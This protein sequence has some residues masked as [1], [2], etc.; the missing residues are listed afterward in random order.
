MKKTIRILLICF[1]A[2]L[3]V[4]SLWKLWTIASAYRAGREHYDAL[5]HYITITDHNGEASAP[6]E[7]GTSEE[8]GVAKDSVDLSAWPQVDFVQLS[9]I[10]PDIVGWIYIEG[11]DINYP[12]VQGKDNSYYLNRLF[13]G[14]YNGSGSIFMDYRC[15]S[16]FS[17]RNSVIYGHHM[18]DKSMFG[19]LVNYK[20]QEFYDAHSVALLVTPDAY[21]KLQIFSGYVSNT[22]GDAWELSFSDYEFISWLHDIQSRSCFK[23]DCSPTKTD[24]IVTLSTCTYEFDSAKFVLHGYISEVI[25]NTEADDA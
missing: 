11:T 20:K 13:D 6:F 14:S 25:T 2:S 5:G 3:L 12:I 16:D 19:G 18:G 23:T 24:R 17:G 4:F 7:D 10:N 15:A 22:K 9:K 21:Y 1:F 8:S